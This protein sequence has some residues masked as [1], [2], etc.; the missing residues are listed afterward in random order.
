MDKLAFTKGNNQATDF[1]SYCVLAS[2]VLSGQFIP[3]ITD[4]DT[5]LNRES[6]SIPETV[7]AELRNCLL[8]GFDEDQEKRSNWTDVIIALRKYIFVQ[9]NT[10]Y[11]YEYC[12]DS[13]ENAID[14]TPKQGSFSVFSTIRIERIERIEI[15]S[16]E[17]S[18]FLIIVIFLVLSI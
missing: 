17:F 16:R 7:P 14:S 8:S 12:F 1:F 4:V 2:E 18:D 6:P 3:K 13:L 15:E 9:L 11:V 5:L 10:L